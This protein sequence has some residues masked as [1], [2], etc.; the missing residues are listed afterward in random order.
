MR[1]TLDES[2]CDNGIFQAQK[3]AEFFKD[4]KINYIFSSP[5]SRALDTAKAIGRIINIEARIDN[6]F[7]DFDFGNWQGILRSDIRKKYS[8][9]YEI[10]E[11]HPE[12]FLSSSGDNLWQLQG[13][14]YTRL[15]EICSNIN[16][17]I[18]I[19][20]HYVTI[21]MLLL[22][23]LDQTP[24]MYWSINLDNCSISEVFFHNQKF[25]INKI[26]QSFHL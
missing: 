4:K 11:N 24:S 19:V 21:R 8:E 10:Y 2:L 7:N 12:K 26:N 3:T 17:N 25:I 1:G 13:K 22:A 9:Q 16:H 14:A 20:S 18:I 15:W 6:S 23:I 5:L